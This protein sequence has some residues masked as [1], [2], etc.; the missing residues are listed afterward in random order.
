MFFGTWYTY[1]EDGQP[2]WYLYIGEMVD[3]NS[4]QADMY[5]FTGP[6]LSDGPWQHDLLQEQKVGEIT[7][8]FPGTDEAEVDV[9]VNGVSGHYQLQPFE[10]HH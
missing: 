1:D 2:V 6:P 10:Q 5:R 9:T 4:A 3:M 7:V 8:E